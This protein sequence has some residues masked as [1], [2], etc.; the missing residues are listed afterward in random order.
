MNRTVQGTEPNLTGVRTM[1]IAS[2][3]IKLAARICLLSV[4]LTAD[5]SIAMAQCQDATLQSAVADPAGKTI[6][7]ILF[8]RITDK[9]QAV[10]KD[11]GSWTIVD[12]SPSPGAAP[13]RVSG[14]SLASDK[15]Y[16]NNY[17]SA[18][19]D[20]T[21]DFDSTRKYIVSNVALTFN[22]CKPPN[23]PS[24]AVL[25]DLKVQSALASTKANGEADSDI[26]LAGQLEG[27]R[28]TRA[29]QTADIKVEIPLPR[30]FLGRG[31]DVAPF[32]DLKVS[33]SKKSDA[34]SLKFG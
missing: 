28:K 1:R 10:A 22:G 34:D 21:G 5:V 17:L 25:F 13:P 32:F 3:T 27:S 15:L 30:H 26:Y 7:L 14:V 16:P 2:L 8:P 18:L 19:L 33:N 29:K 23:P 12:I 9:D 24:T 6:S 11:P 4:F 31:R 20:Y